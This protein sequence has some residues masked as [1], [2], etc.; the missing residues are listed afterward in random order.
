MEPWIFR[1]YV[2]DWGEWPFRDWYS[3][4][5]QR[6]R[7]L[8]DFYKDELRYKDNWLNPEIKEFRLFDGPH[9][10]LGEI[11]FRADDEDN[12]GRTVT[13]RRIRPI[14]FLRPVNR[15]FV[16]CVG[17]EE[18]RNGKYIPAGAPDRAL[19]L[20][21]DFEAGKGQLYELD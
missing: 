4:Q 16:L 9:M 10:P 2:T 7:A 1:Q 19:R 17:C 12:H 14:G 20:Y 13:K 6:I 15:D 21:R 18:T 3:A 5:T 8:F 11:R